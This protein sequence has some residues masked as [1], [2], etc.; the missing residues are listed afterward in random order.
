M[1]ITINKTIKVGDAGTPYSVSINIDYEQDGNEITITDNIAEGG[2][3]DNPP[4]LWYKQIEEAI[5]DYFYE[6][7]KDLNVS[8]A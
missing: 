4:D 1:N 6:Q 5:E 8:F 2:P 3:Y 7:D